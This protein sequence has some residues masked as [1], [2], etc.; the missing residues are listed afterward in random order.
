TFLMINVPQFEMLMG[1]GATKSL[2][3]EPK[4]LPDERLLRNAEPKC[5]HTP[6]GKTLAAVRLRPAS[7]KVELIAFFVFPSSVTAGELVSETGALFTCALKLPAGSGTA[8]FQHGNVLLTS[9]SVDG[10]PD[11][12]HVCRA[13]TGVPLPPKS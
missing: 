8:L 9:Q 12:I 1:I 5:L 13:R 10:V 2:S 11:V 7:P 3:S 6:G 4:E